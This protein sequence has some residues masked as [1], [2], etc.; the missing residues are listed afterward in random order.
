MGS[1]KK[2]YVANYLGYNNHGSK[3]KA[4]NDAY[5]VANITQRVWNDGWNLNVHSL[6]IRRMRRIQRTPLAFIMIDLSHL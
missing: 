1:Y 3:S 4:L 5:A 2:D 6:W